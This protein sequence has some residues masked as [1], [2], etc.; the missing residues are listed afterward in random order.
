MKTK[1]TLIIF[2]V[3]IAGCS[4]RGEVSIPKSP[5]EPVKSPSPIITDIS[6]IATTTTSPETTTTTQT[7]IVSPT[8]IPAVQYEI[9]SPLAIKKDNIV[10]E[11]SSYTI[12]G[13]T[14][15]FGI[16]ITGLSSS[17]IPETPPEYTFSPI[18]G[19][20]F[21]YGDQETPL[22]LEPFGGGG[23]GGPNEDGMITINQDFAYTLAA[24]F[25]VGQKQ[26]IIAIVTLHEM[27]GITGPVRFDLEIVPEEEIQG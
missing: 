5:V 14:F 1:I 18:S 4:T 15:R 23:G 24:P 3:L 13:A 17:Q 22:E 26:H 12:S 21:F 11:V 19:I 8:E 6:L 25:P 7:I 27:F 9:L 2:C 10:I 16:R 20:E